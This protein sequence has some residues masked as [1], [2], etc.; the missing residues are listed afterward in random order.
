MLL[1]LIV[2]SSCKTKQQ[3][4]LIVTNANVYT[5]NNNFDMAQSFAIKEG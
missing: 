4:D 5:V 2:L 3:A 1:M